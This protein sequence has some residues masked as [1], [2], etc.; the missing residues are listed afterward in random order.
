M[1]G[2]EPGQECEHQEGVV[3]THRR[4]SG[5]THAHPFTSVHRDFIRNSPH[6]ATTHQQKN[7]KA[8]LRATIQ[9]LKGMGYRYMNGTQRQARSKKEKESQTQKHTYTSTQWSGTVKTNLW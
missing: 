7:G 9:L 4:V 6:N 5:H 2:E 3:G 8:N 1:R